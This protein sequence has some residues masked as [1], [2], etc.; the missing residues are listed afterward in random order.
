M[1]E[2]TAGVRLAEVERKRS[3]C[4]EGLLGSIDRWRVSL[5]RRSQRVTMFQYFMEGLAAN[6]DLRR[7][8]LTMPSA[9]L[10]RN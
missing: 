10:R 5:D 6:L 9:N 4:G 1:T 8:P 7:S 2:P 3:L